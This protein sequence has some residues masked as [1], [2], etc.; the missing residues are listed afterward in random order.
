MASLYYF[1]NYSIFLDNKLPP[2]L[3]W[4]NKQSVTE[5]GCKL[6]RSQQTIPLSRNA[7]WRLYPIL[8]HSNSM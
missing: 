3:I 6:Q 5:G 1:N 8:Y 2:P 4:S 7:S